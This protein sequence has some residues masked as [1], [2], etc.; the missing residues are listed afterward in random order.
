M[1]GL[2]VAGRLAAQEPVLLRLMPPPGQVSRYRTGIRIFMKMPGDSAADSTQPFML[3]CTDVTQTVDSLGEPGLVRA[4]TDSARLLMPGSPGTMPVMIQGMMQGMTVAQRM[5]SRGRVLSATVS[6]P[7]VPPSVTGGMASAMSAFSQRMPA[8]ADQPVR[9]GETWADSQS[10]N[11]AIVGS[12][13]TGW[14][15]LTNRLD[16]LTQQ[17]GA[18][19]AAISARGS[20]HYDVDAPQFILTASGTATGQT[21]YDLGHGRPVRTTWRASGQ[22]SIPAL[23]QVMPFRMTVVTALVGLGELPGPNPACAAR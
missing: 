2:L 22:M 11:L 3:Q 12:R 6:G 4:V 10:V 21:F 1:L 7:N 16:S 20:A 17:D 18:S 14:S 13:G 19:I 15:R 23:G 8:L 5:D 9:V